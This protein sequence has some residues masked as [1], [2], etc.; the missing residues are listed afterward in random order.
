MNDP[1]DGAP[2]EVSPGPQ[3]QG[4]EVRKAVQ[5]L[6]R[7]G[8][9]GLPTETVYGLGADAGNAHAVARIFAAKGRPPDHP[10]I[11]HLHDFG[12]IGAWARQVPR[13]ARELAEA[14][15][16]GPLTLILPRAPTVL[17]A[18]T[19][20]L[21]TV[22]LRV[23]SHPLAR[24]VLEQFGGGIAAPSANPHKKIS[25]TT[26]QDV[27]E[28]LGDAVDLLLDGGPC[29]LGIESTIVDLSG[30]RARI[31]RPGS[32]TPEAMQ[33]VA[34]LDVGYA[35]DPTLRS[36]GSMSLHYA[37]Q[38]RVVLIPVAQVQQEI[39]ACIARGLRAGVLSARRVP[40]WPAQIPWLALGESPAEQA[41]HLY[42]RLREADRLGLDV[43]IA[44]PPGDP[45]I[46]HAVRDRLR[47]AAGLG[48][49][50][51]QA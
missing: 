50:P 48:E 9:I 24:R 38:A 7:G 14:F 19:G 22:A 12:Q 44:V 32:I 21:D 11:V 42:Q 10:L 49:A 34:G 5:V 28:A 43:L 33:Q 35:V 31:L 30:A 20:G 40:T 3:A 26:M 17:D 45:G 16:P 27:R 8:L 6:R 46:G 4:Q 51:H 23:P 29:A 41:Q 36:P 18:V 25:P 47:R 37:P 2:G 13:V 39:D 15:W 1:L